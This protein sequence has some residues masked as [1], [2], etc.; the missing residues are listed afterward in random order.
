MRQRD[1]IVDEAHTRYVIIVFNKQKI[2]LIN[3]N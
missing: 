3:V 2:F 1:T